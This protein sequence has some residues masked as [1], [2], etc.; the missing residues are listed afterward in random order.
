MNHL[1][2]DVVMFSVMVLFF[3]PDSPTKARWA[4]EDEKVKLVERVR[5]NDQGIKQKIWK[6]C[7]AIEALLDPYSWLLFSLL[8][9][10]TLVVGGVNTFNN[11]LIAKGFGFD[12]LTTQLLGIPLA[13]DTVLLYALMA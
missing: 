5:K 11:L 6:R 1:L 10:Q 4:T 9:F 8:L 2:T 3:L 7:Q 12:V 13:V